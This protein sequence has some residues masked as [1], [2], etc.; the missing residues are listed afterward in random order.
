MLMAIENRKD[1]LV[2]ISLRFSMAIRLSKITDLITVE[3]ARPRPLLDRLLWI[4]NET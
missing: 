1:I 2:N 4:T 3:A